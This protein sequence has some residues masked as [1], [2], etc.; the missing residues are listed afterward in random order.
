MQHKL[1]NTFNS[2]NDHNVTLNDGIGWHTKNDK[3]EIK[4]YA[5]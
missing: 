4:K 1:L 5:N 2:A 3:I